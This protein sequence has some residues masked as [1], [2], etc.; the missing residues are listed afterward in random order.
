MAITV[1]EIAEARGVKSDGDGGSSIQDY[2]D[3]GLSMMG[4]CH[5]CAAMIA[6]YN[7][8]PGRNGYWHCAD[9]IEGDGGYET[10][11]EFEA[12]KGRADI[13][14]GSRS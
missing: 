4:G 6:V 9:C 5:V 2:A 3:V 12:E 8:Y 7:A 11:E 14:R 1:H 10:V 13:H